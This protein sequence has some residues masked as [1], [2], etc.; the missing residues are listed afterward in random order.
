MALCTI[1]SKEHK[2]AQGEA[3][4]P[5]RWPYTWSEHYAITVYNG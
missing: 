1:T 4:S 2:I 5:T 3:K